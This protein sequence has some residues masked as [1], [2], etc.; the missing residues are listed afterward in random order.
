[1]WLFRVQVWAAVLWHS[2]SWLGVGGRIKLRVVMVSFER[3]CIG[4][5]G[6]IS[7]LLVLLAYE[8]SESERERERRWGIATFKIPLQTTTTTTYFVMAVVDWGISDAYIN[9]TV[10]NKV[11]FLYSCLLLVRRH[12]SHVVIVFGGVK[13]ALSLSRVSPLGDLYLFYQ[14]AYNDVDLHRIRANHLRY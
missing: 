12:W 6:Y 8:S 5:G 9:I 2:W 1:M 7:L 13:P 4:I 10:V 14:T 11:E 3:S